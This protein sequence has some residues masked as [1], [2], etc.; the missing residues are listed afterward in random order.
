MAQAQMRWDVINAL[1]KRFNCRTYLEVGVYKRDNFN[2]IECEHKRCV[3][4]KHPA[5]Y[6]MTSDGFFRMN[7]Y[8]YDCI[9]LDGMHTAE[10]IYK[11][12][13]NS[14]K[15]HPKVIIVHDVNPLTEWHTRP[16]KEYKQ[17][18]EWNGDVY[19]GFIEFKR[20]YPEHEVY[21][22]DVD[23]GCGVIIPG[24]WEITWEEFA[25]N[26]KELLSLRG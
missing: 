18:E 24:K 7:E 9:F 11:D 2:R 10:Q 5:D 19:K 15:L 17:G 14:L 25:S 6:Y 8:D 21:T 1:I 22:V 4:P 16:F 20:R 23:H 12:I 3:D 13:T 26:R